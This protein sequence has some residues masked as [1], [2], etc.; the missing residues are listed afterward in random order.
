MNLKALITTLVL[1]SSTMASADTLTVSGSLKLNIGGSATARPAPAP[2]PVIVRPAP[3]RPAPAPVVVT[4]RPTPAPVVV[5]TQHSHGH[6]HGHAA[7]DCGTPAPAPTGYTP[8]PSRPLPA[9]P[10][11]VAPPA[12]Q[13]TYWNRPYFHITNTHV[14]LGGSSYKG[15]LG[16][17]SIKAHGQAF[18]RFGYVKSNQRQAW[19][20]LT[21]AT[22]ID[23]NREFFNIG[24]DQG[25]M[26]SLKLEALGNGS[27]LIKQVLVE[28]ADSHGKKTSQ[29]WKLGAKIDRSNPSITLDLDGQYRTIKRIVVYGSTDAGSAY[30]I[31]AM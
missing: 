19:F 3:V 20:D 24:A 7:D 11:V 22:R 16:K 23:S 2:A 10:V 8:V 6:S 5:H 13:D 17:S 30:K 1:G 18:N 31:M 15:W 9:R 28:Y 29:V 14:S 26:R 21:E 4:Q 25:L 12:P 27:S